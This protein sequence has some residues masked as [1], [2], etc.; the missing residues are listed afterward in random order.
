MRCTLLGTGTSHGIPVIA[1]D[2]ACCRSADSRDTRFRCS[3]WVTD[4]GSTENP[5]TSVLVDIGPD[6]RSQALRFGIRKVDAVLLTHGHAD[7]MNGMDDIR[8]F[9]HTGSREP[10]GADG[11]QKVHPETAGAGLPVYGNAATL[12]DLRE[13]FSY[14]FRPCRE[15]GGKPKLRAED[16]GGFRADSPLRVGRLD[17]IPVPI[18]H[19]SLDVSGWLIGQGGKYV[20]YLTDCNMVPQ[21]SMDIL[22]RFGGRI[23]H[24]VVDGLRERGHSTHFSFAEAASV[25]VRIGARHS[26][27]THI[28]HDMTHARIEEHISGLASSGSA[29]ASF[30]SSGRTV[31]PAYDG[32]VLELA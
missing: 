26:W 13:R 18:R 23:E 22:D 19:G 29:L 15:G 14:V 2:C 17:I 3:M 20:A 10:S 12:R 9:S 25:A 8:I 11:R 6:F 1:C 24:L 31:A 4:G 32:L 5:E 30:L 7:H 27:F 16:C 21:A 28:C